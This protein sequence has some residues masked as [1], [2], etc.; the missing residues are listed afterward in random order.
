MTEYDAV[1]VG[2][3]PNGL[4]AAARLA[5]PG[6]PRPGARARPSI[7]GGTRRPSV[8][9][10]P[11]VV[12]DVC[13]AA[14]PF[15]VALARVRRPRPRA[16]RPAVAATRRV[17]LAHPF[18]D[19]SAAVLDRDARRHRRRASASTRDAYRALVEPL[20]RPLGPA[21]PTASSG[22]CCGVP[23]HPFAMA[24]FGLG[25][26]PAD[27]VARPPV[28]HGAGH[29]A[30]IAGLAAHSV[31]TARPRRSPAASACRS[32]LAAHAVG[33]PVAAGGSQAIADALAGVVR[34]HGGEIVTGHE[35][36]RLDE[37]PPAAGHAARRR[38]PP[39]SWP[40][41]A[42]GC[43]GWP[44]RSYRALPLRPGRVQGR[45]R[46]RRARC[47]GPTRTARRAGTRAPRRPV[48]G[49]R[50]RRAARRPA[51]TMAA[52]PFV[53]VVQPTVADPSRAPGRPRTSLW[54]Y[55]HVPH[56][57]AVRRQRPHRG[58]SST[59]SRPGWR[60]LVVARQV[61]TAVDLAAYNPNDVGGDIAGGSLDGPPARA[62]PAGAAP[63]LRT[64]LPGVL[65]CSASTPPG[66]GAHGMCGWHAAGDALDVGG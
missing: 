49:D 55:C 64:P 46:P 39:A 6:A 5:T 63:P 42:A 35:V 18:D 1:V 33:W 4:T 21:W 54:A 17:A 53:L 65:L 7:G 60:D 51:G 8:R 59:A 44:G 28:P 11:G 36:R 3:G 58:A 22:R 23:P 24:R 45:L 47:R 30:L 57:V 12:Y 14:H 13:S 38:P 48:R 43:D 34:A 27:H 32:A 9:R 61:R 50:R 62:P 40:W 25:R 56:G 15:G 66:A 29:A 16:P 26:R 10:G 2:A 52:R 19:G 37:L 31:P 20:A 41:P